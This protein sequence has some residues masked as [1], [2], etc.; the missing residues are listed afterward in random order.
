MKKKTKKEN[1]KIKKIR[2]IR[3]DSDEEK[4]QEKNNSSE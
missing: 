2:K 4:I 1:N 3:K